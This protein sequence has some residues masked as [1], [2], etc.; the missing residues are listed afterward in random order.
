MCITY[1]SSLTDF[2]WTLR[3]YD[4]LKC[5]RRTIVVTNPFHKKLYKIKLNLHWWR[6]QGYGFSARGGSGSSL[7]VPSSSAYHVVSETSILIKQQQ[8]YITIPATICS[9]ILNHRQLSW[10]HNKL[11]IPIKQQSNSLSMSLIYEYVVVIFVGSIC[12]N[13]FHC[14]RKCY[15]NINIFESKI[16]AS[17][18]LSLIHACPM[19]ICT[20]LIIHQTANNIYINHH[21]FR[22]AYHTPY[23]WL[24]WNVT[25]WCVQ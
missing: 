3:L 18:T 15:I 4:I 16:V 23:M 6:I 13:A 14:I 24:C 19:S 22:I 8:K 21:Q 25:T 1:A 9:H 17:S 11:P 2:T 7:S 5:N 12:L 20:N 10:N